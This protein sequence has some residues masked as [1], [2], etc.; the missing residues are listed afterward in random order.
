[1]ITARVLHW[2]TTKIWP[3]RQEEVAL[4]RKLLKTTHNGSA[5]VT[6]LSKWLLKYVPDE[7]R[8]CSLIQLRNE[9]GFRGPSTTPCN[10]YETITVLSGNWK[11]DLKG[12]P[13]K[14][15]QNRMKKSYFET[16]VSIIKEKYFIY[17]RVG[18]NS[19]LK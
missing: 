17:Y 19:S 15:T 10:K 16:S 18:Y 13:K 1:M 11:S 6:L 9:N 4:K 8:V 3:Q 7:T 14:K 2:G 5:E 12:V